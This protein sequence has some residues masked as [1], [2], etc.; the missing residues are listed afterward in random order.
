MDLD[1]I[2]GKVLLVTGTSRGIG[3]ATAVALGE[4]GVDLAVNYLTQESAAQETGER[5]R[6]SGR[7]A[8][9]V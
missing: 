1:N 6:A 7:R 9:D 3:Q 4:A 8:T 5:V 2:S